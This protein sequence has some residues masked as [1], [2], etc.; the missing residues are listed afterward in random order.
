MK[1]PIPEIYNKQP[2]VKKLISVRQK[3]KSKYS[4]LLEYSKEKLEDKEF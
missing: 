4:R 1:N 2:K 3:T